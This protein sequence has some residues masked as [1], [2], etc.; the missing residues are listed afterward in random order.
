VNRS[1]FL[2]LAGAAL[3]PRGVPV[4]MYHAVNDS[5]PRSIIA[6]NLTLPSARF[7]AQLRYLARRRIPTLTAGELVSALER[8]E[9]PGGVVLTFDDGYADA[10]TVVLPLLQRYRA[11][12]TFFI[13]SG[14]VGR[15]NHVTWAQL[16]TMRAAGMEIGAHGV[17]HLDLTTLDRTGQLY[18]AGHCLEKLAQYTGARPVTYAYASGAY[19]ATTLEVMRT[20]GLR[21][22]WTE[23]FGAVHDVRNPYEMPRLRVSRDTELEGFAALVA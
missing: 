21:S 15:P 14:S 22:G 19:N 8:G 2:A 11:R 18:E 7:E 10:A 4:L 1:L 6:R 12:A 3:V 17:R 20:L 5:N 13:N 16:R 9:H 23:R